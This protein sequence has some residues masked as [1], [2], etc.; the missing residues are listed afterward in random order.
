MEVCGYIVMEHIKG[1]SR[2]SLDDP[3]RVQ[4]IARA[5]AHLGRIQGSTP[6]PL[7]GGAPRGL[8]WCQGEA[9][10]FHTISDVE[11]SIISRLR[12]DDEKP[13]LHGFKL[14]V[15]HLDV[16]PRNNHWLEDDSISS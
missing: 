6:G 5:L 3:M 13:G 4:Q 12:R 9:F 16:S 11:I 8:L 14:V 15:C 10:S 2:R 7:G 1:Q